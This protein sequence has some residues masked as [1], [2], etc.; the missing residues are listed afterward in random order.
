MQGNRAANLTRAQHE[1]AEN[2]ERI[3]DEK[4]NK[5]QNHSEAG[6]N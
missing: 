6:T 3:G 4:S 2:E 1:V 5:F